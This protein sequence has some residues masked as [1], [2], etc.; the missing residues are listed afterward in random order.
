MNALV[1]CKCSA[2]IPMLTPSL[3]W[4]DATARSRLYWGPETRILLAKC[5]RTRSIRAEI[6]N[7]LKTRFW[8]MRS[9]P[10]RSRLAAETLGGGKYGAASGGGRRLGSLGMGIC[11][12]LA[13]G[14][15]DG[16][17][18]LSADGLPLD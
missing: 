7:R 6:V 15:A 18:S 5:A 10:V 11:F 14:P 1:T 4:S 16:D 3:P 12:H 8:N 2:T 13:M 17:G 9:L